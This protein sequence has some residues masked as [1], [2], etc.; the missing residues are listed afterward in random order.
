M[1]YAALN[2]LDVFGA[3]I[4]N[5]YLEAPYLE[6]Y[7]ITCGIEW[8]PDLLSRQSKIVRA[9]YGLKFS[10]TDFTWSTWVSSNALKMMTFGIG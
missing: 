1:L 2:N 5:A 6:Q 10:G 4:Q 8:G 9:L 7:Y 3:D